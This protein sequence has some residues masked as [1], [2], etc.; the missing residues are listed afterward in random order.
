MFQD[1]RNIFGKG[2]RAMFLH[3]SPHKQYYV[4]LAPCLE[5]WLNEHLARL[6]QKKY[7]IQDG[8]IS[9][10]ANVRN[11]INDRDFTTGSRVIQDNIEICAQGKFEMLQSSIYP[12]SYKVPSEYFFV[13]KIQFFPNELTRPVKL[14]KLQIKI[15]DVIK[16][17]K[18]PFEK[19]DVII[20]RHLRDKQKNP[21]LIL[22]PDSNFLEHNILLYVENLKARVSGHL[23]YVYLDNPNKEFTI[24]LGDFNLDIGSKDQHII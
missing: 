24:S 23:E 15:V 5:H 20:D 4:Y 6:R 7:F 14:K 10:F 19:A 12:E 18:K 13:I 1:Y 22:K 16:Q 11:C 17:E 3:T 8:K 2:S 21:G 9:Y